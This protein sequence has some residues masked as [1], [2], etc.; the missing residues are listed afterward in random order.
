[1][2]LH[3]SKG[4]EFPLVFLPFAAIGRDANR[5][6]TKT[7]VYQHGGRRVRQVRTAHAHAGAPSW[8]EARA[9]HDDENR[10]EDMRILYVGLTRA[11][12][13]LWLCGGALASNRAT[14]LHALLAGNAPSPALRKALGD[15]L[16][17]SEGTPPHPPLRL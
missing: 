1:M 12:E 4:L 5:S 3:K 10:A 13:G 6:H 7:A 9:G 14:A 16:V 8:S 15:V 11:R 2:T 17:V